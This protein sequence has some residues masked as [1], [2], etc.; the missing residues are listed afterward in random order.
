VGSTTRGVAASWLLAIARARPCCEASPLA[1]KRPRHSPGPLGLRMSA[2]RER[3]AEA[4]RLQDAVEV[5]LRQSAGQ[6]ADAELVQQTLEL[7]RGHVHAEAAQQALEPSEVGDAATAREPA[8]ELTE[9][10]LVGLR[11]DPD[12]H[13]IV[14]GLA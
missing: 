5:E 8:Q 7:G 2:G 12:D 14:A 3:P 10:A 9:Q 1:T 13:G 11:V 6:V 4:E